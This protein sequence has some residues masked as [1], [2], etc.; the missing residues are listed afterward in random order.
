VVGTSPALLSRTSVV[1]FPQQANVPFDAPWGASYVDFTLGGKTAVSG[2]FGG[3]NGG[4]PS[5]LSGIY[6]EDVACSCT[7][8]T[9]TWVRV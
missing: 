2:S 1:S 4:G 9:P 5:T 3:V 6:S 8:A 7:P